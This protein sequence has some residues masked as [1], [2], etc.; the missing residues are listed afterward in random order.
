[1][2]TKK[3][4]LTLGLCLM[5]LMAWAQKADKIITQRNFE[6]NGLF[7]IFPQEYESQDMKMEFEADYTIN[8]VPDS[9]S[10]QKV[11]MN[12]TIYTENPVKDLNYLQ[13]E[14]SGEKEALIRSF[15]R[16]YLE[17]KNRNTWASRFGTTIAYT[18]LLRIIDPSKQTRLIFQTKDLKFTVAPEKKIKDD[19]AVAYQT[20]TYHF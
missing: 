17:K 16:Y 8:Y 14:T 2:K 12:F 1:M 6:G 18:D 4:F 20:L 15:E 19:Y 9:A 5:G 13:I 11:Q 3:N 10:P 7:F